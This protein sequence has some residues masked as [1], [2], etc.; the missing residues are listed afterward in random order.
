MG[1]YLLVLLKFILGLPIVFE[2]LSTFKIR[3]AD[4]RIDS[5]PRFEDPNLFGSPDRTDLT[6]LRSGSYESEIRILG[7]RDS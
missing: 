7:I 3:V 5:N 1:K 2:S 6:D 4:I